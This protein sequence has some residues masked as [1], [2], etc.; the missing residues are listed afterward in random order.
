MARGNS[1]R[2]VMP[3][4]RP[5]DRENPLAVI[6]AAAGSRDRMKG[7][8]VRSLIPMRGNKTLVERQVETIWSV[9]AGAEI[10]VIAG[11]DAD[12]LMNN[13]PRGVRCVENENYENTSIVRSIAIGLRATIA[14]SVMLV[15]GD[16]LFNAKA[17]QGLTEKS[18]VVVD[19]NNY[20]RSAEVGVNR[21]SGFSVN[22]S[23]DFPIKWGQIAFFT[24]KELGLLK[25]ICFDRTSCSFCG[26]EA[27]NHIIEKGGKFRCVEN[28]GAKLAEIDQS[29]DLEAALKI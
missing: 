16:M 17:I 8:G 23:Y 5:I 20:M 4:R 29:R 3:A 12:R 6:I 22:F 19:S 14:S 1:V 21:I 7:L 2:N 26:F 11:Y 18:S 25:E 15:C 9:Y 28:K 27:L 24:Q 13:V 10:I